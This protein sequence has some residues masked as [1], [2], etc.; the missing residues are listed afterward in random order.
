MTALAPTRTRPPETRRGAPGP[1][2]GPRPEPR[3]GARGPRRGPVLL[4]PPVTERAEGVAE[5]ALAVTARTA[6]SAALDGWPAM[7]PAPRP[8]VPL[9]D[10]GQVCGPVVL[11][12]VEALAGARPLTQLVRW[13]T[14]AVYATLEG[15]VPADRLT[16]ALRSARVRRSRVCRLSD[17][18]AECSVV[19]QDG[20]RIR[21]AAVRLEVHRGHW[22]ATELQI[23]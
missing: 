21:A 22:R 17:T 3:P 5:A 12:A 4:L 16:G 2:P 18:V 23:G 15:R 6:R 1:R 13:V 14:P 8:V 19:V 7:A 20:T 10:P 11:A 9:T